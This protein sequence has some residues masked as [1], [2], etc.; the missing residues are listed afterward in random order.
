M[1]EK[2]SG[3]EV[4]R[5]D[6]EIGISFYKVR[7]EKKGSKPLNF[8]PHKIRNS[9]MRNVVKAVRFIRHE[10]SGIQ[11]NQCSFQLICALTAKYLG[12]SKKDYILNITSNRA[13]CITKRYP[14]RVYDLAHT[15]FLLAGEL[16]F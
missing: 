2:V 9:S 4:E 3:I 11:V 12:T 1:I 13:Y 6:S 16:K 5:T 7:G 8:D 15:I 10:L 14:Q